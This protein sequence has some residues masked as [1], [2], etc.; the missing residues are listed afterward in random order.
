MLLN[1]I[2]VK[3]LERIMIYLILWVGLTKVAHL[4]NDKPD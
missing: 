1:V 4:S 2:I 3:K